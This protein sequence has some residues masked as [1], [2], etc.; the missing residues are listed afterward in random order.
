KK[1]DFSSSEIQ[2]FLK[3]FSQR[4]NELDLTHIFGICAVN[5]EDLAKP[6]LEY[7]EERKNITVPLVDSA[8][9]PGKI[10]EALWV[11]KDGPK[12]AVQRGCIRS[13]SS[14]IWGGHNATH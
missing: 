4:L 10:I 7:T 5:K 3:E 13:C 14:D 9:T 12:K 6:G 11:F 2:T 8:N 1:T